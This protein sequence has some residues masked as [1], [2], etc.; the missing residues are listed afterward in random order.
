MDVDLN[1]IDDEDEGEDDDRGNIYHD[2]R[3]RSALPTG[4]SIFKEAHKD[5]HD[6]FLAEDDLHAR[7]TT[8]P[9]QNTHR[10]FRGPSSEAKARGW[11]AVADSSSAASTASHSGRKEKRQEV[12]SDIYRD[13]DEDEDGKE[14]TRYNQ[15]QSRRHAAG[16]KAMTGGGKKDRYSIYDEGDSSAS[17]S[18]TP[19]DDS[20]TGDDDRRKRWRMNR[21]ND[22]K[23]Q[24]SKAAG[25]IGSSLREPLLSSASAETLTKPPGAYRGNVS[26]I[27]SADIYAYPHP[28][29]KTSW[30]PW[31]PGNRVSLSEYK[32]KAALLL[33]FGVVAGTLSIAV[34]MVIGAKTITPP[35]SPSMRPSPYY[36]MTRSIPILF[37]LTFLSIIAAAANLFFLRNITKLGGRQILQSA[38]IGVPL[39]LGVG[40]MWAF[41]GS[42]IYDDERWSGGGWSTT[43]LRVLSLLPLLAAILFARGIWTRRASLA[44]SLSVLELSATIVA[45]HPALLV[46]C[47]TLLLVFLVITAPFLVIFVR[48]FLL[49]HFG[50]G[51]ESFSDK[52]WKTDAKARAIAW[53]T[54]G[55][56]LWT[57]SVLR[58]IQ[59]VTVAGVISHWYFHRQEDGVEE[60]GGAK[61]Y[62]VNDHEEE[63]EEEEE[64]ALPGPAPGTWLGEEQSSK[65]GPTQ[66]D[67][68]RAS[69]VRATGPALG[70][71]CLSALVLA[72][73]RVGSVM[74]TTTRWINRK[75]S[76]Q[77]RFP[78]ILQPMAHLAAI[79][80]GIST[81]L[82]GFSDYAL[83]Y[84]GVTGDS[85]AAAARRSSR[86]VG[87]QS[88]KTIMEGLIINLLLDLTTLAICFLTGLAGFLF[89][90]H[91]LHVP[92]DAPLVGLLCALLPYWTLRLCADILSNSADTLYLCFSIDEASGE[93]HCEKAVAAFTGPDGSLSL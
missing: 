65:R 15:R 69:F 46:L 53:V 5:E 75:L 31:A 76:S 63:E 48:L 4:S 92:A 52:I 50:S 25:S 88:V 32:D 67:I 58:G 93:Q 38:L 37:L 39:I 64:E 40:W 56:W 7:S 90:A 68:V 20:D 28:P 62:D 66:V 30:T 61:L 82:Q 9:P 27:S 57:W 11:M 74:A 23:A 47:F 42:F 83:V 59:R 60:E 3:N 1:D 81:I 80:A 51:S 84:V 87:R 12:P 19:S 21:R 72:V 78:A 71:I 2:Q 85:F 10:N 91:N 6:P 22:R 29:S 70:T 34:W 79:L 89:S 55:V 86:L 41:A 36:T 44:R 16:K 14:E 43:G 77:S 73:A 24:V 17:T 45:S 49:G 13:P 26:R 8:S 18:V 54:L 35:S 33:W